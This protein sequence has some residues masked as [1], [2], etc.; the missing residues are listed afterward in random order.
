M[1]QNKI[2]FQH[3]MSLSEF[4]ERYGTEAQCEKVLD[5][6]QA[7]RFLGFPKTAIRVRF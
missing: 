3:G 5:H 4:I 7:E 2:Q 6:L 1:P